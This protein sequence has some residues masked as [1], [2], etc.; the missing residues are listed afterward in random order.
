M[1]AHDGDACGIG[2]FFIRAELAYYFR[3]GDTFEAVAWDICKVDD[4]KS[5]GDFDKLASAGWYFTN[6]L[7]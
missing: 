6:S 5:V 2:I 1:V 7:A 3:D 4:A